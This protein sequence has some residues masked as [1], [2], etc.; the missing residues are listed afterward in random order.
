MCNES[1]EAKRL[2]EEELRRK[3]ESH[4]RALEAEITAQP[5]AVSW[6]FVAD[7]LRERG[8]STVAEELERIALR[9]KI[10]VDT[11]PPAARPSRVFTLTEDRIVR[12]VTLDLIRALS[13]GRWAIVPDA[14][15]AVAYWGMTTEEYAELEPAWRAYKER[16][17]VR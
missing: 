11:Q 14:P 15:D 7:Q 17:G 12:L 16:A 8:W 9:E 4:I 2:S 3:I 1:Q 5:P 10:D 13:D 6:L